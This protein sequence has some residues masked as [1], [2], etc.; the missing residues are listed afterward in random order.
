VTR[1]VAVSV[2]TGLTFSFPVDC[3]GGDEGAI[4]DTTD[5]ENPSCVAVTGQLVVPVTDW[6]G[7]PAT[8]GGPWTSVP[9]FNTIAPSA[10]SPAV[11]NSAGLITA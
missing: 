5:G 2:T 7:F 4:L 6:G 9:P 1:V 3:T 10:G 11:G 8:L